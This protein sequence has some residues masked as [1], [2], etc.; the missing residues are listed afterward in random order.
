MATTQRSEVPPGRRTQNYTYREHGDYAAQR[1]AAGTQNTKL[2]ILRA[3]RNGRRA[4]LRMLWIK[5][6]GGSIPP[7]RTKIKLAPVF[8]NLLTFTYKVK[9]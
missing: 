2:Y 7:A 8:K 6:L 9:E 1:S 3:W 5:I 4:A